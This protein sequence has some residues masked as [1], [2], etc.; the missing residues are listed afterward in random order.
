MKVVKMELALFGKN[1]RAGIVKDIGDI[2]SDMKVIKSWT[3][4]AKPLLIAVI[5]GAVFFLLMKIPL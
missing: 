4:F 3:G 5:T 2:K 1:G